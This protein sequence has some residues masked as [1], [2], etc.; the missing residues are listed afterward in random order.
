MILKANPT[1]RW[2]KKRPQKNIDHLSH[3][4]VD[5]FVTCG[6]A[7]RLDKLDGLILDEPPPSYYPFGGAFHAGL[8][9]FWRGGE[10][11]FGKF[12]KVWKFKKVQYRGDSWLDLYRKGLLMTATLRGVF[13]GKFEPSVTKTEIVDDVD[14]GFVKLKR[15]VDV[16]TNVSGLQVFRA[17]KNEVIEYNGSI[18]LDLKTSAVAYD[19][20]TILRSKQLMTYAIPSDKIKTDLS[21]YVVVTKSNM[22]KVQVLGAKYGKEQVRGQVERIRSVADSIHR[23]E[24]TQN[25]GDQCRNCSFRHLCYSLP[26][27]QEKYKLRGDR[28]RADNADSSGNKPISK[29]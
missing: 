22:P 11:K 28:P 24:F 18:A 13:S 8:R 4:S 17:D 20:N 7:W 15:I 16:V 21:A 12:W 2:W 19:K 1:D 9:P 26:G 6:L 3:S 27:W 23:G 29:K 14:L 5:T 25:P 10:D